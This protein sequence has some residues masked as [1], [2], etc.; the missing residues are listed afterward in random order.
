MA[1]DP[2]PIYVRIPGGTN[3]Q[4]LGLAGQVLY[5][6]SIIVDGTAAGQ[7]TFFENDGSTIIFTI[8]VPINGS[9]EIESGSMYMPRGLK[10]TTPANVNCTVFYTRV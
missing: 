6:T 8:S 10:V 7:V 4:R 3:L 5:I 1:Q 9:F 2:G